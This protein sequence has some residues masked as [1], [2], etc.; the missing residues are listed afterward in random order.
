VAVDLNVKNLDWD[1]VEVVWVEDNNFPTYTFMVYLGEGA[2]ADEKNKLGQTMLTFD[3]LTS[4]T[5]KYSQKALSDKLDFLGTD[6]SASVTH[7]YTTMGFGGLVKDINEVTDL[8]CHVLNEANYLPSE[9]KS[10]KSKIKSSLKNL[11]ASHSELANRIFREL[12][13]QGTPFA[14]PTDGNLSSLANISRSSLMNTKNYFLKKVYKKVFISGPKEVLGAKESFVKNCAWGSQKELF[15]RNSLKAVTRA[16][17]KKSKK[18]DRIDLY[19]TS[20]KGANQAQIRMGDLLSVDLFKGDKLYLSKFTSTLLG[21]SFTS[22][23]MQELRVKRGLTYGAYAIASP[24]A[25]YGRSL[26]TTSTRNETLLQAL[27]V[28]R[29]TLNGLEKGNISDQRFLGVKQY[30]KGSHLFPFEGQASFLSNL[31]ALDH[32]QRPYT[33]LYDFPKIIDGFKLEDI[34]G[35]AENVFNWGEMKIYVLGDPSLKEQIKNSNLFNII[36]APYK[37]YL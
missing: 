32:L 2:L 15:R 22:L 30:L 33:E 26:V 16:D 29:D 4:G 27:Y 21:G 1:G 28:T 9:I 31:M 17:V 34:K 5:T 19:F 14:T 7:E 18:S 8:F 35:F 3:L 36:E 10:E 12:S 20:V 13:L 23:L 25:L 6:I 37:D 11:V 24:Q